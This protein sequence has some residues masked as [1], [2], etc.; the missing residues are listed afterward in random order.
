[1]TPEL[2]PRFEARWRAGNTAKRD[3]TCC[4]DGWI[5]VPDTSG[6]NQKKE[7][8]IHEEVQMMENE[9]E[10][11]VARFLERAGVVI[12][13]GQSMTPS[14]KLRWCSYDVI[15]SNGE[16]EASEQVRARFTENENP[17][18]GQILANLAWNIVELEGETTFEGWCSHLKT[19]SYAAEMLTEGS[20]YTFKMWSE[21]W[22]VREALRRTFGE[23]FPSV[24]G[25]WHRYIMNDWEDDPNFAG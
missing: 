18:L 13:W 4:W 8:A 21:H 22:K 9:R 25:F 23:Y 16:A 10:E 7:R 2:L 5:D 6:W 1:M 20:D 14:G 17:T 24:E 3:S 12:E 19:D 11:A 15:L